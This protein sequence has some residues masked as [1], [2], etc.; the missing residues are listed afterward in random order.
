MIMYLSHFQYPLRD[1]R[2]KKAVKK[3]INTITHEKTFGRVAI[4]QRI[5]FSFSWVFFC[6]LCFFLP[7]KELGLCMQ[8]CWI[9]SQHTHILWLLGSQSHAFYKPK[10]GGWLPQSEGFDLCP[11]GGQVLIGQ[12]QPQQHSPWRWKAI[13]KIGKLSTPKLFLSSHGR[14]LVLLFNSQG[15][16]VIRWKMS[17]LGI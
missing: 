10:R 7:L 12:K 6:F 17:Q 15:I 16:L 13:L 9:S 5:A 8:M 4:W 3:K 1:K 14:K 11:R 2:K